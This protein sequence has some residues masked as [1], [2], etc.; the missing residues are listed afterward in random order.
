MLAMLWEDA[1]RV[2]R[3]GTG[4]PLQRPAVTWRDVDGSTIRTCVRVLHGNAEGR[5]AT[6]VVTHSNS[7]V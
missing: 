7:P 2:T 6:C 1:L 5:H 4:G 3:G